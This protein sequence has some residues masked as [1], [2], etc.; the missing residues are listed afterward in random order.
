MVRVLRNESNCA[1]T[2]AG[3]LIFKKPSITCTAFCAFSS[4]IPVFST[5]T[6]HRGIARL[7]TQHRFQFQKRSHLFLRTHNIA[8]SVAAVRIEEERS[9]GR[10]RGSDHEKP[11]SWLANRSIETKR[12]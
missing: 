7:A 2:G 5:I 4:L 3:S 6:Y 9:V 12:N 11:R 8:L 1:A 10:K